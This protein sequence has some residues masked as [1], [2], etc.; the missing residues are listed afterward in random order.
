MGAS[1]G[2]DAGLALALCFCLFFDAQVKPFM[3]LILAS[4]SPRRQELLSQI[5]VEYRVQVQAVDEAPQFGELPRDYVARLA[6]SKAQVVA[7]QNPEQ[8]VLGADTVVTLDGRIITKPSNEQDAK[9]IL[10]RLSGRT[11]EVLTAVALVRGPRF[12]VETVSTQVTFQILS[13][14][15]IQRYIN[16]KEPMDKAGAYGIQGFGGVFVTNLAGSYS[17]VVGLP[18]AETAHLLSSYQIPFWQRVAV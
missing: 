14:E 18:L 17:N 9:A 2:I 3:S 11:H 13:E 6:L 16:T 5:G 4:S 1:F 8:V 7:A 10:E 12:D 15:L